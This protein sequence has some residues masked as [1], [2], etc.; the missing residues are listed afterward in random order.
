MKR[1]GFL[2]A[3]LLALPAGAAEYELEPYVLETLVPPSPFHGAHGMDF[4]AEGTLYV[5]DILGMT[6][7]KVDITT[8]ATEPFI[9][10]PYGAADDVKIG[11]DGTLVWTHILSGTIYSRGADGVIREIATGLPGVNTVGFHPDGRLFAT[12]PLGPDALYEIDMTG[13]RPPRMVLQ[14]SGSLNG[15]VILDDGYLY[16]PQGARGNVI[17]VDLETGDYTIIAEGFFD[18]TGVK[19]DSEGTL[20][21]NELMTGPC[22]SSTKTQESGPWSLS[23]R[24]AMTTSP[25]PMTT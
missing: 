17:R 1:L 13:E 10:P 5:G 24:R 19:S 25:S 20:Y 7:H 4:D 22:T 23:F 21:V 12:Q 18:P 3:L 14:D 15:F 16:G 2:W 9:G 8:G 6:V 11:P